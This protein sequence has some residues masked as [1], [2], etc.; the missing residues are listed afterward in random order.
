MHTVNQ[1][2]RV[3]KRAHARW[4]GSRQGTNIQR[5]EPAQPPTVP[6]SGSCVTSVHARRRERPKSWQREAREAV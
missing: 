1:N 5:P 3:L 4:A 6:A 2:M